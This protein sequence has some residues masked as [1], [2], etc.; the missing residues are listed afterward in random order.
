[1]YLRLF[2]QFKVTGQENIPAQGPVIIVANHISLW[3]PPVVA[4]GCPRPIHFMAKQ[5]LFANPLLGWLFTKL[6]AFPV[7]RGT[8]DRKAYRRALTILKEHGVLGMFPEGTRRKSDE[9]GPPHQGAAV[10]AI[11]TQAVL[12]PVGIK[13]TRQKE[14]GPIQIRFGPQVPWGDLDPKDRL[15]NRLLADRIMLCIA[16]LLEN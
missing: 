2:R 3:D 14:S 16:K 13:G 4:V 15:S 11:R 5:E 6:R 9:L 10:L 7:K 8:P 12:I 1:M